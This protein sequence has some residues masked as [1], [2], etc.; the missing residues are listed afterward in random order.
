MI[1]GDVD[2]RREMT[3]PVTELEGLEAACACGDRIAFTRDNDPSASQ[4]L[5]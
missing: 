3:V 1:S 5:S 4:V 2:Q